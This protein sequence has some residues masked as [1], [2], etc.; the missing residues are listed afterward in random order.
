[1]KTRAKMRLWGSRLRSYRPKKESLQALFPVLGFAGIRS[2]I[3]DEYCRSFVLEVKEWTARDDTAK[4]NGKDVKPVL[5]ELAS[6]DD[7]ALACV[8]ASVMVNSNANA[9]SVRNS[10]ACSDFL[11]LVVDN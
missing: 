7:T 10:C 11:P 1:M 6:L 2:L 4:V 8:V 3:T 5:E 9:R